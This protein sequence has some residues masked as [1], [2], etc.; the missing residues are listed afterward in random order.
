MNHSIIPSKYYLPLQFL[1]RHKCAPSD[2]KI[3]A[4]HGGILDRWRSKK[5][6]RVFYRHKNLS[7]L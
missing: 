2:L 4:Q 6:R 7:L 1:K 3:A 5:T